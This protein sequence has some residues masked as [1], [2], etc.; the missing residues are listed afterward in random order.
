MAGRKKGRRRLEAERSRRGLDQKEGVELQKKV[1]LE[2]D[3]RLQEEGG[4]AE[5]DSVELEKKVLLKTGRKREA[6]EEGVAEATVVVEEEVP[7][8]I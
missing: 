1:L 5:E 8:F 7:G 6:E 3:L 4:V 2:E